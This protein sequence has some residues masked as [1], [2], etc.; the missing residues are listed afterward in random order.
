MESAAAM[1]NPNPIYE[2]RDGVLWI[3]DNGGE[4]FRP[5]SAEEKAAKDNAGAA[6]NGDAKRANAARQETIRRFASEADLVAFQAPNRYHR[7]YAVN[8]P[9]AIVEAISVD[10]KFPTEKTGP[11]SIEPDGSAKLFFS[12]ITTEKAMN[13]AAEAIGISIVLVGGRKVRATSAADVDVE[14][15]NPADRE[16]L[17]AKLLASK[18][19]AGVAAPNAAAAQAGT[20]DE[21]GAGKTGSPVKPAAPDPATAGAR[22]AAAGVTLPGME[23]SGDPKTGSAAPAAPAAS[24]K[25]AAGK[26]GGRPAVA[27]KK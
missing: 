17:L 11:A 20:I 16:A 22:A 5:A 26:P 24:G 14:R 6:G 19:G 3:S 1:A 10:G 12:A 9:A 8:L 4:S 27:G 21:T 23:A 2:D 13:A 7:P 18:S 15:M 25:P